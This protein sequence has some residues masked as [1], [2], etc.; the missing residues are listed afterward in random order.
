MTTKPLIELLSKSNQIQHLKAQL[1]RGEKVCYL[2]SAVPSAYPALWATLFA[3]MHTDTLLIVPRPEEAQNVADSLSTY[4]WDPKR[5]LLWPAHDDLPYERIASPTQDSP[6]RRLS[7]L[8]RILRTDREPLLIVASVKSILEPTLARRYFEDHR[9]F[10][11][12]GDAVNIIALA[13]RV[14]ELGYSPVASVEEV[15]QFSRRGG[16]FD[17]WTPSSDLPIRLELFGD[18]VESI[19]LFD[20]ETQRS[21]R[22]I[23]SF[24]IISPYEIPVAEYESAL[25]RLQQIDLSNLRHEVASSWKQSLEKLSAGDLPAIHSII[26]PYFPSGLGNLLDYLSEGTIVFTDLPDRLVLTASTLRSHI[27]GMRLEMEQSG[28]IPS[29]LLS[30]VFE[31][32][33][34]EDRLKALPRIEPVNSAE[35]NFKFYPAPQI[36]SSTIDIVD[37]LRSWIDEGRT[38]FIVTRHHERIRHV[39]KEH[40]LPLAL[41]EDVKQGQIFIVPGS[42]QDGWICDDINL[43]VLSDTE[44]WGYREPRRARSPRKAPQRVFLADLQ[45]GSYVVHV[46]H[47]VAKYVGNVMRGSSGAEREYLVLEYA[48]GDRLYV[49]VDQIDRISP[50][51]GGG[52]PALSRLGTADWARTKRRAKKAADQLAKELLQLYAAREIAKGHSFSPDNELHKEFESA[53]P[54]VETDDQL[55][56]IED[57]KAD[58]ESPKPM[59]RLICGD[60]GYGKTEV[61]LRAAF[62]AVADGKQVAVLVPTTVL[63]LQHYETFRS[64]FNPFG[65]RVEML[66]RLRTKKERDQVLED[67]QKGNVDIVIGTHTILQKN[68]VFKDLGLVIVDEEQRF[69]VKHKETLKQIR[70]QVDV[71]TLTA[72]P[73]PRTLQMA[74]SGVRDMSVIETAPEDRLPVYTY[75]VPK[76]DSIIRDSIIRELERGGQVF[77]VHNRVQDI[78]KVAHKLQEMVPEA[79]ITVAHGQMPEQQL[80][81]VM[82]DFMHHHYDVLVCTTIIESGLDIPNANTLIVDDAT[83]MGLAQ[84][85]QLR[86]RVGRSSNRAYAYLMYRPDARMTEDAQK[87]LEAISEATQLGAGFRVAMKDLEI[88][89]AGNFLGPEQSG[90]VY[91]IGLELYTQMIERAVQELR[92]GQPISEP[93]AVTIDLPIPALIP[94][95]YVSDRDTRIRLYRRLAST[96]TAR[97]LRSMESE[98]RDRFGPLPEEAINLIKLIDLKIVAAKAGVTAIRAADNE[99]IIKT[100][101]PPPAERLAHWRGVRVVPGQV[102][103]EISGK[104]DR[105]LTRLRSVLLQMSYT[106]EEYQSTGLE[107]RMVSGR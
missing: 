60:V 96:S 53:F 18:E 13:N 89:G 36:R 40:N 47:G 8:E 45:P 81:Q 1:S 32:S 54:Y 95:H 56:A 9:E 27:E 75:I 92:T 34:I 99:V 98:M 62:K 2:P 43:V 31:W 44:L 6:F 10:V 104:P 21:S 26:A 51:I 49:P 7:A 33:Y 20:P 58:M 73:I 88:R 19:R 77:Y 86:G 15:G 85:Y 46:D 41:D 4:L 71:L 101:N 39:A 74:L 3:E 69:G 63:A 107:D 80:E 100:D 102:R 97:E 79:R 35:G 42:I 30:P 23:E 17:I 67:L 64:R 66:S 50:Y 65:I 14:A 38:V 91:A 82:L 55:A 52:E 84:L 78:Y 59:D 105:W 83:H 103:V 106:P 94:E 70:T 90:H 93:P 28:D 37:K 61:A 76:N 29:N 22:E 87:R 48:G 68:V 57:V 11:K 72:T 12:T 24:S 16:I 5:V 25:E